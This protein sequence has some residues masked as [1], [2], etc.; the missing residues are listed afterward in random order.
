[1]GAACRTFSGEK[2]QGWGTGT[3]KRRAG[4]P[5][6]ERDGW[7]CR[8]MCPVCFW[9]LRLGPLR[10]TSSF[11]WEGIYFQLVVWGQGGEG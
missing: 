8:L 7:A 5:T 3:V 10:G 11:G 2:Q 9:G 6:A 4:T 1:M